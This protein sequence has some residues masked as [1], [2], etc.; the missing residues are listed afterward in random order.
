MIDAPAKWQGA[1][2]ALP[3]VDD[4]M[5][6]VHFSGL[7]NNGKTDWPIGKTACTR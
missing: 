2:A 4:V 7:L 6:R 1:I 5:M 3:E